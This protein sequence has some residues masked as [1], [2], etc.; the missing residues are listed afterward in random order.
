MKSHFTCKILHFTFFDV[1]NEILC[2]SGSTIPNIQVKYGNIA[3]HLYRSLV[4]VR[5]IR[6]ITAE[7]AELFEKSKKHCFPSSRKDLIMKFVEH[8]PAISSTSFT[9][10][11][12]VIA[13][14][15]RTSSLKITFH[16]TFVYVMV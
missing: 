6:V 10:S 12:K 13:I 2:W 4:K 9:I 16:S 1:S 15:L 8:D 7:I 11:N 5:R 14:Q 3:N